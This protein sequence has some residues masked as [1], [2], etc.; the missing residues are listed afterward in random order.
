MIFYVYHYLQQYYEDQN[1][2]YFQLSR[3][4]NLEGFVGKGGKTG[5]HLEGKGERKARII[6]LRTRTGTRAEQ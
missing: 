4:R 6:L 2:K 3:V 1:N 5:E